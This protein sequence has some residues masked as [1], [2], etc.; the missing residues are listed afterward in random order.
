MSS[1]SRVTAALL[2]V[3]FA[4]PIALAAEK[5]STSFAEYSKNRQAIYKQ[6][7]ADYLNRYEKYRAE[8]KEKWGVAELSS[9]TEYVHYNE[10]NKSKVLTDFENDTIEV[11]L[12]DTDNL[13]DNE[14]DQRIRAAIIDSLDHQPEAIASTQVEFDTTTAKAK[15]AATPAPTVLAHLGIDS[16]Q[17][18]D[19]ILKKVA[20]V[21]VKTQQQIVVKRTQVRLDKQVTNIEN[22][23]D[24][25]DITAEQAKAPKA[26]VVSLKKEQQAIKRDVDE[27]ITK[28]IKTY[29]V[30]LNRDRYKKA[31]QYLQYVES[32]AEKWQLSKQFILA[33]METES[34]FNPLAKSYIPAYGLMQIVPATAGA[35]VNNRI[36]GVKE[37]PSPEVLFSGR[38]NIKYGAAYI[39][40][41]MTQYLKEI[42]NPTSRLYCA[43][44]AYNTGI[45]NL[46]RAFNKGKKGRLKAM[47]VIN[48]MTP[49]EVYDVIK[50][51]THTETQRYLDKVLE[52]KQYFSQ[53]KA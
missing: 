3:G 38:D 27:L 2:I 18:L 46:A 6:F 17:S 40:I 14:V 30:S 4:S 19:T 8:V 28:N 23:L 26:L 9:K 36:L 1:F 50:K 48:S 43:I 31:E 15:E 13:S 47:K 12:L 37:K 33:V 35:D 5:K 41:L 51:R 11:S 24:N 32:N 20:T 21:P 44:A 22:F 34:H 16:E 42:E 52:S 10:K 39:H 25:D 7:K 49:D 45:G 29:K 53:Q